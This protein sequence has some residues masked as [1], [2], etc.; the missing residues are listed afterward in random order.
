MGYLLPTDYENF[1]LAANTTDDWITVASALMETHCRRI[2]LN[3]TQYTERL[4]IV[5]GSQTV[6]LTYLPLTEV[7]PATNPFVSVQA[8]YALGR[9]GEHLLAQEEIWR[10]FALPGSWSTL[11]PTTIDWTADGSL[12]LPLNILGLPYNEL[13]VTYTGGLSVIPDAVKSAC[14]L[15]V[16]NAQATPGLNVQSSKIDTMQ[17][18]YFS[19]SLLDSNVKTLLRPWVANRLG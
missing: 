16:K 12:T 9:R 17:V 18:A 13:A 19:D 14:A 2:S 5:S 15:I 6:Q 8:R 1:G 4:R 3:V 10:A 7:P 11:D